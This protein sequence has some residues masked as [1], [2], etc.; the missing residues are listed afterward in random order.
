MQV[1]G[2]LCMLRLILLKN[3]MQGWEFG[4]PVSSR[5]GG[6][7]GRQQTKRTSMRH[8]YRGTRAE[9]SRLNEHEV[10]F[11][12]AESPLILN[13]V[14]SPEVDMYCISYSLIARNIR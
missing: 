2:S 1:S 6:L 11:S 10:S 13:L 8:A 7:N 12:L 9:D 3:N 14:I 5:K 4:F